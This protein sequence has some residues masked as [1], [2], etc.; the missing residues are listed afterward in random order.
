MNELDALVGVLDIF[1]DCTLYHVRKS[2]KK[3]WQ[4]R[5]IILKS[6]TDI[7]PKWNNYIITTLS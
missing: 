4:S 3:Y 6:T 2:G 7:F 1:P 5:N